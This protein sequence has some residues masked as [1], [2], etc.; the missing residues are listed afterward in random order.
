MRLNQNIIP[1]LITPEEEELN[2]LAERCATAVWKG[3]K[4]NLLLSDCDDPDTLVRV[5]F[6]I[7]MKMA[8]SVA[9]LRLYGS[10]AKFD[11]PTIERLRQQVLDRLYQSAKQVMDDVRASA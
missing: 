4:I 11:E 3:V 5:F 2:A 9:C 6:D 1:E 8:A 7:G 10:T